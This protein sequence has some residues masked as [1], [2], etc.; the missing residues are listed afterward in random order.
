MQNINKKLIIKIILA[1]QL[2]PFSVFAVAETG[3]G[4]VV[5]GR[6]NIAPGFTYGNGYVAKVGSNQIEQVVSSNGG[7]SLFGSGY[8]AV[9]QTTQSSGRGGASPTCPTGQYG[10]YP[11]CIKAETS[12]EVVK[13]IKASTTL[14]SCPYFKK[15]ITLGSSGEEVIKIQKFLNS[16]IKSNL[17]IDGIFNNKTRSAVKVFQKKYS[18]EVLSF[19]KL[20]FPTGNWYQSTRSQANYLIGCR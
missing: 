15:Y 12:K 1:T 20:N 18:K 2:L 19:W 16:E 3:N 10:I 5:K 7:F 9:P 17:V 13:D 6:F 14:T 4:Y 11:S 8:V